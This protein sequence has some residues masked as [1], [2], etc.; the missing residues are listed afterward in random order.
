MLFQFVASGKGSEG[1]METNAGLKNGFRL[2]RT[3]ICY[4]PVHVAI[5]L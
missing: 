1:Y 2:W 3:H 4:G 5:L